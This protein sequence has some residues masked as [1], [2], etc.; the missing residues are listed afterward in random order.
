[1]P[2]ALQPQVHQ[3][4]RTLVT[5]GGSI[6]QINEN[7]TKDGRTILCE[8]Y[9][10]A[11]VNA[12][13]QV[14]G[15]ASVGADI[16]ERRQM[17][18]ARRERERLQ[19]D[20]EK[21]REI[22]AIKNNMMRTISHEFRT[23]LAVISSAS[24]LLTRYHER[25]T[26]DQ[27]QKQLTTITE[28][29]H[30][31]DGMVE[32]IVSAVRGVFSD[33]AFHP[34][35]TDLELLGQLA[36][37]ELHSTVGARHEMTFECDGQLQNVLIDERLVRRILVNLLS[38]AT[39]YSPEGRLIRLRMAGE[40]DSIVIQVIDQGIG[41][42]ADDQKRLFEPFFRASNVE[43]I[44]GIGLGLSIVR[45]CVVLHQGTITTESELDRGTT[46]T[47]RLPKQPR[48]TSD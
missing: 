7:T 42:S 33:F 14:I 20:L 8:W 11:L 24:S 15:V 38:N 3:L 2:E 16:T 45:D 26:N 10:T 19:G 25:L 44:S 36:V 5:Q 18:E 27:R 21:E 29:V 9:N 23:P 1:V 4:L 32:E 17:E 41:I 40:K 46:F 39:K 31:L 13:G 22:S 48:L 6:H 34:S 47:V 30:R 35:Y 37:T 12:E 43:T 28:Q